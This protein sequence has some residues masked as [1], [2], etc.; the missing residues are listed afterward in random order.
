MPIPYSDHQIAILHDE[1]THGFV[2]RRLVVAAA[3]IQFDRGALGE[4]G[5]EHIERVGKIL[6]VLGLLEGERR[7]KPIAK[8]EAFLGDEAVRPCR[9]R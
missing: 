8:L 9:E 6:L 7:H 1:T 2:A 3:A 5:P 4:Q